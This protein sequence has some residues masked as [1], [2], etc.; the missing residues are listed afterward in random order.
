[1]DVPIN[2]DYISKVLAF[3]LVNNAAGTLVFVVSN[4]QVPP[5]RTAGTHV[6]DAI[7]DCGFLKIEITNETLFH[8]QTCIM[9]LAMYMRCFSAVLAAIA[10]LLAQ[11]FPSRRRCRGHLDEGSCR[12][13]RRY[14]TVNRFHA[15]SNHQA[16][17]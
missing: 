7:Y 8:K 14:T 3:H 17:L 5:S 16:N 11:T 10:E 2:I 13:P 12:Y 4:L 6:F 15:I 1:M 9:S